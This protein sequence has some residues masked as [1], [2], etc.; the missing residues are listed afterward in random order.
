MARPK[1]LL[2]L[3]GVLAQCGPNGPGQT[4]GPL[5]ENSRR[6]VCILMKHFN[7]WIFTTRGDCPYVQDYLHQAGLPD[8]PITDKKSG[9]LIVDDK[10]VTFPGEWTQEFIDF[11]VAFKPHWQRS[12]ETNPPLPPL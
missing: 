5:M 7:V 3:D 1:L 4:L 11:L 9:G 10:A 6:A 12:I 2:D 8:L